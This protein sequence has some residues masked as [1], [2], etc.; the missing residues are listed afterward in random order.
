MTSVGNRAVSK[1]LHLLTAGLNGTIA[2]LAAAESLQVPAIN[3]RQIVAENVSVELAEKSGDAKHDAVLIYCDKVSNTLR[4][5]FRSFSGRIS[6][7][8]EVRVTHDRMEGVDATLRVYADAI[9]QV[10]NQNRGDWGNGLF[11]GGGYET[12]FAAV[13]HGGRNFIQIAKVNL[14]VDASVN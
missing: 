8:A 12:T 11:Y 3:G 9:G 13:K 1:V 10:L 6:V 5:K 7:T 14:E 4:E 2:T